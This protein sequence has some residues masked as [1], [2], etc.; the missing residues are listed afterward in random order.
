LQGVIT[1]VEQ[2][3]SK[4]ALL[5][6]FSKSVVKN[7]SS[8]GCRVLDEEVKDMQAKYASLKVMAQSAKSGLEKL[9][10]ERNEL[11]RADEQLKAWLKDMEQKLDMIPEFGK[12]LVEKKLLCEKTK[13]SFTD[14]DL[15]IL[16]DCLYLICLL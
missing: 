16:F 9:V 12:D 3:Q 10:G 11:A 8:D 5:C 6:D 15:C 14:F 7:T 1:S 4:L 13:V 2:N